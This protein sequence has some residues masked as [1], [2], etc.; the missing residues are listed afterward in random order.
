MR[1]DVVAI[2]LAWPH[3]WNRV[4]QALEQGP[5]SLGTGSAP[6][7]YAEVNWGTKPNPK[8]N[9]ISSL[10]L[11]KFGAIRDVFRQL[12]SQGSVFLAVYSMFFPVNVKVFL[13]HP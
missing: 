10:A 1:G 4:R 5:T 12:L 8:S 11:A 3:P 6:R 7:F 2:L 13:A 9:P